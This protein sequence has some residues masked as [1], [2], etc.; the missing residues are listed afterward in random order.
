MRVLVA[1]PPWPGPGYGARS[2]VRWPHRRSDKYLEYPIYLAYVVA[3]LEKAG[4]D[5]HFVDGVVEELSVQ[6]FAE[7]V[8]RLRPDLIAIECSTPSI[9]K[10]LQTAQKVKEEL[11]DTF[12]VLMGSHPTYFHKEILSENKFVDAIARGEFDFTIRELALTFKGQQQLQNIAG[13]SY[14]NGESIQINEDRPLIQDLD[15]LPFPA[16]HIVKSDSYR[17]AVFTGRRCTTIVS[18]RG[19]PYQCVFCLWPRTMYGRKFRKRSM[20]NVVDEVQHVVED[21]GVD[22]IYF[23]DDCLTLDRN[24]LLQ[25]CEEIVRR[26]VKV[27]WM[28]QARVDNADD[29]VLKAMK[30]AGCH[31]IKYGVESGSQEMLDAMK[32]G[33]TL[34]KVRRAFKLT[35][36]A[37]I[38]T[39][40]FFLLGLPWETPETV[41]E[42]IEFAKE[43]KP[44]S[45]QFAVVVPHPGTELYD[46]CLER[47]WLRYESWDDFDC[48]KALIETDNLSIEDAERYRTRAYK[49]FYLRP[50]FILRTTLKLW[51]PKEA[52]R[53][54]RSA[55]SIMKRISYYGES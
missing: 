51:N 7:K 3:V 21:C 30:Q 6:A 1:N 47:G 50:S 32:K 23:D 42:T 22:E 4:V 20:A 13:I 9:T 25:I 55:K 31:Y 12:I 46:L 39:Q 38:K 24:R 49:E 45:A 29:E 19:C 43:I 54:I 37:G 40:A 27:K 53:I 11:E 10:D 16:R 14:R 8:K 41:T 15:T 52:K 28:C 2:D 36:K 33:I 34:D 26:H 17:E 48:R 18:S 5:V 44:D 35:R